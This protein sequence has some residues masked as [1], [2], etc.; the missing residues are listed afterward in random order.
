MQTHQGSC[1]CGNVQFEME[2]DVSSVKKCN[3][4]F[5]IR[6]GAT[7]HGV[8]PENFR[9]LKG[10]PGEPDGARTY[11]SGIFL[12]HFCPN[13]GIQC[14]TRVNGKG[15]Y[16]PRVNVN[17]GCFDSSLIENLT[18]EELDGASRPDDSRLWK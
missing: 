5:C 13:C 4:S 18:P 2:T 3:C 9:I 8:P 6:R 12:H 17:M 15:R 14:F 1:H 7:L 10:T 16:S 11:G